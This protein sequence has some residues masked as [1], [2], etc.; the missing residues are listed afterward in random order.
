V[1][2]NGFLIRVQAGGSVLAARVERTM[3]GT[4]WAT[5][6]ELAV[7]LLHAVAEGQPDPVGL[8]S[9]RDDKPQR[10][11]GVRS[12]TA[13][14]RAT[15]TRTPTAARTPAV[16]DPV[17]SLLPILD[18]PSPELFPHN[19]HGTSVARV[20]LPDLLGSLAPLI[21]T[22]YSSLDTLVPLLAQLAQRVPNVDQIRLLLGTEP[23][24]SKRT[25]FPLSRAAALEIADYWRNRGISVA[26]CGQVLAA[27]ELL[28]TGVLH[29][30]TS[31]AQDRLIH[32]KLYVTERSAM[33]GSSN[34][35]H[36]GLGG[37][38]ETNVRFAPEH[39][40][41]FGGAHQ[42]AERLWEIGT[43]Y[44][45]DLLELLRTL[46]QSVT[47]QEAPGESVC[48][49]ARGYLGQQICRNAWP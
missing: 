27:I 44:S 18:W 25:F 30:R 47:W 33:V 34:F 3:P 12:T 16:V 8:S 31:N 2:G 36:P 28:E 24:P 6:C 29:T 40:P 41:F 11:N 35:S 26:L 42:L 39:A 22:G 7:H 17:Q 4:H 37:Q 23:H 45:Q 46:L 14:K 49:S 5:A 9:P 19:A 10:T 43:D 32:G 20:L 38:H 13:R 21:I 15:A 48:R 1:L